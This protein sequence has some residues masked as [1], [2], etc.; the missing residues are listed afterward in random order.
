MTGNPVCTDRHLKTTPRRKKRSTMKTSANVAK[1]VTTLMLFGAS[2]A[3]AAESTPAPATAVAIEKEKSGDAV[4]EKATGG[5]EITF[6]LKVPAFSPRFNQAPVA[7]VND[8][9]ILLEEFVTTL[10]ALH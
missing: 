2:A 8:D 9:P 3:F 6:N 5:D 1:L 10:E 4:K 7:V